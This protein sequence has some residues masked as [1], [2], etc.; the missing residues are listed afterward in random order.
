MQQETRKIASNEAV[1]ASAP[2]EPD[3]FLLWSSQR[4]REE[5]KFE[6]TRGRVVCNMIWASRGHTRVCANILGALSRLLDAD[7]FDIGAADFAVRTKVGVRSPDI[8]VDLHSSEG[9]ELSTSAP[10]FIAEVL[11]P[12]T[13]GTDFTEKLEEYTSIATLQTYL[14]SSQDE[15]RAW[16]WPRLSDGSWPRLP[17]ELAGREGAIPLV[18]LGIEITMAAIFRG[19]PDAPTLT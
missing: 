1:L 10:I 15:P 16:V 8:V 9:H 2:T 18:G 13:A 5:G 12:S 17:T 19:I 14:I 4:R 11:S 7:Q 6:L 3:A